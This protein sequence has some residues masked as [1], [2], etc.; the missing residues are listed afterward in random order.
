MGTT[1]CVVFRG[2]TFRYPEV[3][4]WPD[5]SY[6]TPGIADRQRG[7][8]APPSEIWKAAHGPIP[9][10]FHVH[11][12]DE[13]PLNNSPTNLVCISAAEHHAEHAA[14]GVFPPWL[15]AVHS[16]ALELAGRVAQIRGRARLAPGARQAGMGS[17]QP[18]RRSCIQCQD[19]FE[20][21]TL[22]ENDRFCSNN[23]KTKWR[24]ASGVDDE[25]RT[26]EYCGGVFRESTNTHRAGPA[27]VYVERGFV[28]SKQRADVYNLTVDAVRVFR[29]RRSRTTATLFATSSPTSVPAPSS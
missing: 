12:R 25:D 23:C 3:P 16:Q 6:F 19:E 22:R 13:N 15:A 10:G 24:K 1:D 27:P 5:R 29:G 21:I 28:A 4:N 8:P 17:R 20:S 2:V 18:V 9:D 7:D 14:P 26:C 11:H